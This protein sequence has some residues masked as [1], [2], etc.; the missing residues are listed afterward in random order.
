MYGET[1]DYT[2]NVSISNDN[3]K[4]QTGKS[5]FAVNLPLKL[6]ALLMLTLESKAFPYIPFK[7]FVPHGSET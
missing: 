4:Y 5:I 6:I 1:L 2:S 3:L 7:M